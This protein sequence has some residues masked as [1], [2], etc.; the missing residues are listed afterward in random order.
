[1]RL[2]LDLSYDGTDFRG[3][4]T[5]PGLR[6][7]Q[8]EVESA[9]GTILRLDPAPQLT[10]AG[11]TDAGVHARGQVAHVDLDG[12]D[13]D[14]LQRRLRRL[15]P[16]DIALRALTVAPEGFDARFAALERRYVYRICD[17]PPGP[18]PLARHAVVR[19]RH[20]LDVDAMNAAATHLL[21]EHDF[22]AFCKKREGATTIRTLLELRAARTGD[23]IE[24]TVRADA[25]C[26]SMVR[27]LMGALV[28][29]GEGRFPADWSGEVLAAAARDT[30]V[31]VMP[32]HGLV[33]E[34]VV[35]PDD[36]GLAARAL[37]SRRRRD[38]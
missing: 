37:Q 30:R 1:M 11:R 23:L 12:V 33:L 38:A 18:D 16:D 32:A 9:L 10:C 22:A 28:A 15:L 35:Y 17:A 26:H 4:A 25:F 6:T 24:T 14:A 36:S 7:V 2:R 31:R 29:V 3:W 8:G 19:W 21:G 20:R 13:P 34:E 27:A 5:Q